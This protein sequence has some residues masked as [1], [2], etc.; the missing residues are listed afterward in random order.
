MHAVSTNSIADILH[1]NNNGNDLIKRQSK[2]Y[3]TM[4]IISGKHKCHIISLSL[5]YH[6]IIKHI[7]TDKNFILPKVQ[8]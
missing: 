4:K 8:T 2:R 6:I 3:I 7:V 1:F 5:H